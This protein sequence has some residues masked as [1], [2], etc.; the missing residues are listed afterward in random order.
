MGARIALV[1]ATAAP[2][3]CDAR[4]GIIA[5]LDV[6]VVQPRG[7]VRPMRRGNPGPSK[8]SSSFL[9]K[10]TKTHWLI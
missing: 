6:G 1:A 9:K 4:P 7:L 8:K 2:A 10:R 5:H 3:V